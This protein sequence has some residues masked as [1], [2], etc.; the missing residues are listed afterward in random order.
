M[1]RGFV[2]PPAEPRH[3]IGIVVPH[4]A[5]VYSGHV[6]GAVYSELQIPERVIMLCPNHT[7][8]GPPLSIMRAGQWQTPLGAINIDEELAG[9]LIAA[10]PALGADVSAHRREHAIEVQLPFLQYA[11]IPDTEFVP[12]TV[13]TGSWAALHSLGVAM[14]RTVAETRRRVLI[15]ASSDM[16]HYQSDGITRIKDKK[17]IDRIL[18]LDAHGLHETVQKENISMCG[19]GPTVAMLVAGKLLGATAAHLIRY[20]TSADVSGDFDRVVGYAG[21][22]VS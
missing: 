1:I 9:A 21:I 6:A 17:A 20:A 5:Y 4:A 14:A 15:L 10:D 13:G 8:Y 22:I 3:A 18:A 11:G 2:T 16:N 7:G 19:F 12:I